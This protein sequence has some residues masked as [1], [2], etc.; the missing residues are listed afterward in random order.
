M[1][2]KQKPVSYTHLIVWREKRT[3]DEFL[4]SLGEQ[5]RVKEK[6][7]SVNLAYN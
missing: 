5:K 6:K 2:S 4:G 3:N 1:K 7:N